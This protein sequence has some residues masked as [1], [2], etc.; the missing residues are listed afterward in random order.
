MMRGARRILL[1]AAGLSFAAL[2]AQAALKWDALEKRYEAQP[3]EVQAELEFVANNEGTEPVEITNVTT[4]CSCTAGIMARQPWVVA[5]GASETLRVLVDLR[6]RRGGLTKTIH[7][8][9]SDGEQLLLVHVRVPPS[10]EMQREMNMMLAQTD[11]QAVL[12]GECASCHVAPTVG[13]HGSELFEAAC[14]ICH[15]AEHRASMVPDLRVPASGAVRDATYWEKW[16][17]HGGEGT[18]MPAFAKAQG[19]PLDDEQ[20]ASLVK[21]LSEHLQAEAVK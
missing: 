12:R 1:A 3:G 10:A 17:R 14:Q 13:K 5:P 6:G 4:S 8:E 16:I 2:S 20:V 7:V 21:Y 18:L 9:T 19:G 15:G 11:R